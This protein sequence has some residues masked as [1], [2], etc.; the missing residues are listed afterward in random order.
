MG[1]LAT[2]TAYAKE[3]GFE[4]DKLEL[5]DTTFWSERQS[6]ALFGFEEEELRPYF[7]LPNVLDGLFGLCKRIF[8]VDIVRADDE[9]EV[10]HQDV[11]FFKVLDEVTGA[12]LAS[13]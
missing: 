1:E 9:A 6:E 12:H 11:Q 10:W 2:L 4:G 8:G 5:W 7:A 3:N 13:F